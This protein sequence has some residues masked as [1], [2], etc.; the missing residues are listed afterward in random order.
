VGNAAEW[1]AVLGLLLRNYGTRR[2]REMRCMTSFAL[3][4]PRTPP[5]RVVGAKTREALGEEAERFN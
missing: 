3:L 1:T 5:C 4:Q 2:R